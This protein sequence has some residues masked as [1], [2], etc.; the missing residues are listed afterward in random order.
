M[1]K[2]ANFGLSFIVLLILQLIFG[3]IFSFVWRLVYGKN[4][5]WTILSLPF[6]LG[7]VFWWVDL[8]SLL[9]NKKYKWLV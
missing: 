5:I 7:F 9:V 1:A 4:I 2:K 3:Y 6:L 8:L